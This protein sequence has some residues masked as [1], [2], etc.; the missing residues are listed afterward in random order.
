[1]CEREREGGRGREGG[2]ERSIISKF[3]WWV[4]AVWCVCLC[5]CVCL[6]VCC[7]CVYVYK[8]D[9]ADSLRKGI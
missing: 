2:R 3:E 6:R 7:V 1:M 9:A 8:H 5:V 4:V